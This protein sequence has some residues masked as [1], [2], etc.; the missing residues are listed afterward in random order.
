[1]ALTINQRTKLKMTR[2]LLLL[3]L[4]M[5]LIYV[6][7]NNGFKDPSKYIVGG[8][9]GILLGLLMVFYELFLFNRGAKQ[10]RFIWLL[11]LRGGIYL[12]SI[13]LIIGLAAAIRRMIEWDASLAE[14]I[15]DPRYYNEYLI[16]DDFLVAVVYS[17]FLAFCVNFVR[18]I[19]RKMGQGVLVSYL[20]GTFYAPVHQA[21]IVMFIQLK[22]AD[23][24]LQKLGP[25]R[26]FELLNEVYFDYSLPIISH[27]GIIYEYV[28]NLTIVT[29]SVDK[30]LARGNAIQ[31]FF[32]IRKH[33]RKKANKY[34]DK[35]G[36]I[37]EL[38]AS[39][40]IGSVI[41][42]EMGEVKTQLVLQGDTMNTTSRILNYGNDQGLDF[43]TSKP[44]LHMIE[45]PDGVKKQ[46]IGLVELRGREEKLTL[47]E[48][49]SS[50]DEEQ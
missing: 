41:R 26:Y 4:L 38:R 44:L 36:V 39:L 14:V 33:L 42:A 22:K 10:L 2:Q 9:S 34:A 49:I 7:F 18:M 12:V 21:R 50:E 46:E 47:Y 27:Q 23:H 45:L 48:L 8:I 3:G 5:G 37:P 35:F 30:G 40:H 29:W 25:E 32:E 20:S 31:T 24:L 13:F 16:Q 11:V 19:S 6:F 28:E 1:M 43:V 17:M 15:V